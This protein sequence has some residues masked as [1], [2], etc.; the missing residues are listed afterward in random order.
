LFLALLLFV[1]D[2]C[3]VFIPR[4]ASAFGVNHP[5]PRRFR[6]RRNTSTTRQVMLIRRVRHRNTNKNNDDSEAAAAVEWTTMTGGLLAAM[7]L[8]FVLMA[9]FLRGSNLFAGK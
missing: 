7:I 8:V 9:V 1:A 6:P 3:Q 4:N 2:E 5:F